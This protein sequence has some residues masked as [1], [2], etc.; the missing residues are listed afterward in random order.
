MSTARMSN[1]VKRK[2]HHKTKEVKPWPSIRIKHWSS[3]KKLRL[4]GYGSPTS[5]IHYSS[6][7]LSPSSKEINFKTTS[8]CAK[9]DLMMN[10][11]SNKSI[12][13]S[14]D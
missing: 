12:C 3:R 6:R 11:V 1:T 2:C 13:G 8:I 4:S 10:A 14:A 5:T 7:D 9:A